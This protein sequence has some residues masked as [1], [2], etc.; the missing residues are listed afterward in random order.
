[1]NFEHFWHR[2]PPCCSRSNKFP[3]PQ[4]L[5]T[6]TH[7]L[8]NLGHAFKLPFARAR[9][10]QACQR[11]KV[12]RHTITP[13]GDFT[14]LA[15]LFLHFHVDHVVPLPTASYTYCL[16]AFDHLS[17]EA[18][19]I[20]DIT[21]DTVVCVLLTGCISRFGC[22]GQIVKNSTFLDNCPPSCSQRTCGTLPL[23][24]EG[25]HHVPCRPAMDRGASPGSWHPHVI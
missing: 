1:M 19:P 13:V 18:T 22:P 4:S 7:L 23:D 25:S 6:A 12:Y 16:T 11:S 20:P 2:T 24:A 15:A 3:A 21:A 14:L 10:C 9:A 17:P 8:G 5:Y